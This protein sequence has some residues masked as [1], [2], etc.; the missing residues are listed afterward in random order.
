MHHAQNGEQFLMSRFTLCQSG[1][2]RTVL[3]PCGEVPRQ[4]IDTPAMCNPFKFCGTHLQC[5][6]ERL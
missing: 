5:L 2:Q 6:C 1:E 3:W 4:E